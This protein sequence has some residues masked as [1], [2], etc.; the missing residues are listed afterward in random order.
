M[1]LRDPK[2]SIVKCTEFHK[3]DKVKESV[4]QATELIGGLESLIT[5]GDHVMIKPNLLCDADYKTG[6]PPIPI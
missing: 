2:V 4:I 1:H 5:P 3:F 6:A